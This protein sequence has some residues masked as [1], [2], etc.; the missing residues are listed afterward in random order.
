MGLFPE[1]TWI[2]GFAIGAAI[3]SFLNVVI[4]RMPLGMSLSEPKNSF[5]PNCKHQLGIPDLVPLLSWAFLRGRCRHCKVPV[6][7]RYFV[8]EL[9]TGALWGAIW[10]Q[11]LGVADDPAKAIA[12]ML[13]SAILVA[14]LFIDLRWYIIPDQLNAWLLAVGFG[15][16]A[17]QVSTG[18]PNAWMWGMPAA[19]A[20]ALLGWGVLW[21]ITF[22]GR[23]LFGKD[24]MGHGDIK[25]ARGMGAVLLPLGAG[26]SFAIAIFLGAIIGTLQVFARKKTEESEEDE[27]HYEPESIRSVIQCGLGYLL[28]IDVIGLFFPKLYEKWFGENPYAVES[29]DDGWE[30]SFSTIPFGPYLAVGAIVVML[31]EQQVANWVGSYIN[32]AFPQ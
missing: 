3:G 13:A 24:A 2:V 26:A 21:G 11:Q 9:I 1:W 27:E 22:L 31:F 20:G 32:W 6:P 5:C 10:Y 12:Y 15:L 30:P 14:A 25:L 18:Q 29:E 23:L 4:Y 17:Y 16:S 28:L 8:V 7:A 19:V